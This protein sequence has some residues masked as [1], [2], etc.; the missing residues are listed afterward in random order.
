MGKENRLN[1]LLA[2][3][4]VAARLPSGDG[5][6]RA[7]VVSTGSG[8]RAAR[9][10]TFALKSA[11]TGSLQG[12]WGKDY[13]LNLSPGQG[14]CNKYVRL[15]WCSRGLRTGP[16]TD[17]LANLAHGMGVDEHGVDAECTTTPA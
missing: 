12:H 14:N 17:L 15:C 16:G 2:V 6:G 13:L 5:W 3:G 4:S 7:C 11:R 9:E 1:L 8:V 10:A